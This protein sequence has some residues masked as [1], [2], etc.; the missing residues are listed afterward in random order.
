MNISGTFILIAA[1]LWMG[2][3]PR[4]EVA[5]DPGSLE[6]VT[7]GSDGPTDPPPVD[8]PQPPQPPQPPLPPSGPCSYLTPVCGTVVSWTAPTQNTDGSTLTDLQGYELY[9]GHQS[10]VY[11]TM[12]PING[13]QTLSYAIPNLPAGPYYFAMKAVSAS[14]SSAYTN[15]SHLCAMACP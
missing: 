14:G 6:V 15:E 4:F 13:A 12:I 8:P 9:Y 3:A 11:S 1:F 7:G 2:C 5:P 10:R